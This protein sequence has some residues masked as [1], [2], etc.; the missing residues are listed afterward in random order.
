MLCVCACVCTRVVFDTQRPTCAGAQFRSPSKAGSCGDACGCVRLC[1]GRCRQSTASTSGRPSSKRSTTLVSH[2][3][4]ARRVTFLMPPN[5]PHA[6]THTRTH[7]HTLAPQS[8]GGAK[9]GPGGAGWA[10]AHPRLGANWCQLS[11]CRTV[12]A[13]RPVAVGRGA[14]KGTYE[15]VLSANCGADTVVDNG[16]YI[17]FN[18]SNGGASPSWPGA[19]GSPA[20]M[21]ARVRS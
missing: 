1:A 16:A 9:T 4:S 13:T 10:A 14:S 12:N 18:L 5:P 21:R 6:R 8:V 17:D 11:L 7:A 2:Y 20:P 15:I 3:P 19:V